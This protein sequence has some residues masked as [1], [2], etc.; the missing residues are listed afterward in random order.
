MRAFSSSLA[1][2]LLLLLATP[3]FSQDKAP[4]TGGVDSDIDRI[5]KL[6]Q[7]Q[8]SEVGIYAIDV[9][10]NEVIYS[11][12]AERAF[13]PASNAKLVTGAAALE[14]LGPE[15]VWVTRI[16]AKGI[17]S[18]GVVDGPLY[19]KGEGDPSLLWEDVLSWGAELAAMGVKKVPDGIVVDDTAWEGGFIPPGFE[20]KDEDASYRAPFGP[21]SLNFNAQT[22]IVHA[23][24]KDAKH[25]LLPPNDNVQIVNK[26]KVVNGSRARIGAKSETNGDGTK[27]TL[28]GSIGADAEPA[29]IKKRIDNPSLFTGSAFAKALEINGIEVGGEVRRGERPD[30]TRTLVYYESEPLAYVVYLMN[31]WSNN[32]MAEMLYRSLG[33]GNGPA[34]TARARDAVEGFMKKVGVAGKGFKTHNGS[35]LYDG[36]EITPKQI[37]ELLDWMADRPNYPEFAASLAVAGT[38]GT[39]RKRLGKG[40]TKGTLRAKTGTLNNV[41]ALSGYMTT[42][43]GRKVAY[44]ILIND[45][46]V[47]AWT[48]RGV[49]DELAEALA[50][51][52]K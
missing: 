19:L 21:V 7:L 38:D 41:T 8:K 50:D 3:A 9:A 48:L 33:G 28:T 10:T 1:L 30:R 17:G 2:A 6:D 47:K 4:G 45:P 20:Q 26:V 52:D 18:D 14:E 51:Y 16:S 15:H 43:S 5:M 36:N 27:I 32:F 34:S 29:R 23:D 46:P 39:M 44:A 40:S 31:K 24:G 49:Q 13:N 11:K 35:G 12:N 22:V 37:V 42:K 25:Y